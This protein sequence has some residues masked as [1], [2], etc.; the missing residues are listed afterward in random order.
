MRPGFTLIEILIVI[1]IV[2]IMAAVSFPFYNLFQGFSSTEAVTFEIKESLR[3][4]E[5]NAR[6]G[7]DNTNF[8]VYF[9]SGQ[10]TLYQG[11]N[12]GARTPSLDKTFSLPG[13]I[14]VTGAADVNFTKNTGR[15]N[16]AMTISIINTD[17]QTLSTININALGLIY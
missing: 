9:S 17:T 1:S 12:Y 7:Q 15:P 8:G 13:N 6:S 4:A 16:T 11:A 14:A 2:A 5:I 10:Y 3:T